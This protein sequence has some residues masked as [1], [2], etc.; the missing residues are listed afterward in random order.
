M[1]DA[2]DTAEMI[3]LMPE[4]AAQEK[5]DPFA[6]RFSRV[7]S[8]FVALLSLSTST[9]TA[10]ELVGAGQPL[11]E[12]LF[13]LKHEPCIAA[14]YGA[15]AQ[16]PGRISWFTNWYLQQLDEHGYHSLL[17]ASFLLRP[18]P[19]DSLPTALAYHTLCNRVVQ[20]VRTN[21]HQDADLVLKALVTTRP[22]TTRLDTPWITDLIYGHWTRSRSY[23]EAID[24]FDSLTELSGQPLSEVVE[25]V[26]AA[27]RVM[28]QISLEA[29]EAEAAQALF[30]NLVAVNPSSQ[31]NIRIL[32][33]FALDKAKKDEWDAVKAYF[34]TAY[35]A[36]KEK[37]KPD[38]S[39]SSKNTFAADA[40]QVVVPIVKEHIKRHTIAETEAFMK[41]C[42]ND[43]GFSINR[44]M[45]TLLANE[46]GA[47]GDASTFMGW[48][49]YC[50]EAGFK[51]DAAFSNA[52]VQNCRRHWK[53]N[54]RD[55][56]TVYRKLK[57]LS[58]DFEDNVTQTI[59]KHSA[60]SDAK[61]AGAPVR[62][63]V[64]SLRIPRPASASSEPPSWAPPELV[65]GRSKRYF[66]SEDDLHVEMKE[67][68]ASGH[69]AKTVRMFT[70]AMRQGM[71][72]SA[73]CLALAVSAA[74]RSGKEK[75]KLQDKTGRGNMEAGSEFD[76]AIDLVRAAHRAGHNIGDAT[77]YL[78]IAHIDAIDCRANDKAEKREGEGEYAHEYAYPSKASVATAVKTV[79][80]RLGEQNY[81]ISG[82]ALNRAAFFLYKSS[83]LRGALALAQSAAYAPVADGGGD[84]LLGYDAY[85]F[86]ILV[87]VYAR[88]AV[89]TG[90]RTATDGAVKA[91]ILDNNMA[92]K[93]IKQ[94]R[95]RLKAALDQ[96]STPDETIADPNLSGEALKLSPLE[97]A[98][99][100]EA[101]SARRYTVT[102]ALREIER[103]LD[104]ARTARKKLA[105]YRAE[106]GPSVIG[107]MQRAAEAAG[108]PPVNFDDIPYLRK[109]TAKWANKAKQADEKQANWDLQSELEAQ[110]I[111]IN[112][113]VSAPM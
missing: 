11:L 16:Y 77:A 97:V 4:T 57:V 42:I 98:L 28:I 13:A 23:S 40:E 59:M 22:A 15:I 88:M 81:H 41:M 7:V 89:A 47:L 62:G 71:P 66:A 45:V 101:K 108:R 110:A 78:A 84:G 79:L 64:L 60:I 67:A 35:D 34:Q 2:I 36:S 20:A 76:L 25:H 65:M 92:Y 63:R 10:D 33:L 105:D 68:F 31:G 37:C 90:I 8:Q 27:Y 9:R 32:G 99:N 82:L 72:P 56:R 113:A 83:H 51:V 44:E 106:V 26:D 43:M 87:S 14:V 30:E 12:F 91:G 94:A 21:Y 96:C 74:V 80:T 109:D 39:K 93:S 61:H 18:P 24:L 104:L 55:L 103:T 29:G 111:D 85:N 73:K 46:Y 70:E 86:S 102:A 107:L 112:G 58:P 3:S 1:Q 50:T 69:A 38:G 52:I 49:T 53:F 75:K 54:F 5:D 100:A 6:K 17:V 48:L 95:R 19:P